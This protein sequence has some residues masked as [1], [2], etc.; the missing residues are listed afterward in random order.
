[1]II[2]KGKP[3]DEEII[4]ALI[5]QKAEFDRSMKG[6]DG[7]ISTDV[8]AIKNTITSSTPFAAVLL[9]ESNN[10]V[11]GFALY[12]FRYSSFKG[13]PSIWLD[14]LLV[15]S[16]N[17]SKGVGQELMK[18]LQLEAN[19][20]NASHIAWTAS[21]NNKRGIDFYIRIGANIDRYEGERPFFSLGLSA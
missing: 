9:A 12:H 15:I 10:R 18:A 8:T 19:L 3:G 16:S 17:R 1:M 4:L 13:Q 7:E 2:R 6:F 11:I 5:Q 20:I 21:P 14:D